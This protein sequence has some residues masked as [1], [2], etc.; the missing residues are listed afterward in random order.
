MIW[1]T[2][3][4]FSSIDEYYAFENQMCEVIHSRGAAIVFW[5]Q[6]QSSL[7]SVWP[8]DDIV[9]YNATAKQYWILH[10]PDPPF[11]GAFKLVSNAFPWLDGVQS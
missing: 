4:C 11:R 5:L 1:N 8:I 3:E 10:K 9:F 2:V 6:N 7:T